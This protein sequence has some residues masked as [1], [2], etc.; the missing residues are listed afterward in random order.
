MN[1]REVLLGAAAASGLGM[2]G[3]PA[4][5][6]GTQPLP[7]GSQLRPVALDGMAMHFTT[8]FNDAGVE[9]I[10]LSVDVSYQD[11]EEQTIEFGRNYT[12]RTLLELRDRCVQDFKLYPHYSYS[13]RA[14]RLARPQMYEVVAA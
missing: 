7:P 13:E 4:F 2:A 5:A 1:R 3:C 12:G 10:V 11:G 9:Q 14:H 8:A 6:A